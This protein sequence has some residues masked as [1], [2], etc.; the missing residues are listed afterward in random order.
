MR[1][2]D[3]KVGMKV[4]VVGC[5]YGRCNYNSLKEWLDDTEFWYYA[6]YSKKEIE[7]IQE[8]GYGYVSNIC[9]KHVEVGFYLDEEGWGFSFDDIE[10]YEEGEL[11]R[12]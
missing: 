4:K 7:Q 1:K 8:Q 10:P 5:N 12:S 3:V 9:E 2:E 11:P 6:D